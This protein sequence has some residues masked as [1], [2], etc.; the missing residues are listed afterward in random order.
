M[1]RLILLLSFSQDSLASWGSLESSYKF[2]DGFSVSE[3]G[4]LIGMT[5]NL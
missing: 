5:L 2:K 4:I 1:R 3:T